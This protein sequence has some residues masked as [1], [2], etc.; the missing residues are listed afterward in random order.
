MAPFR[1]VV[2]YLLACACVAL[3]GAGCETEHTAVTADTP[4]EHPPADATK[5]NP[6]AGF[7]GVWEPMGS[8]RDV[9]SEADPAFTPATQKSI[10]RQQRMRDAGDI[11]YDYS[12]ICIPPSSPTMTTIGP[13]EILVDDKKITWLIEATSGIRWIWMDG[14]G[15]PPLE[16]LRLTANGHAIGR[17]EDDVLVVDSVGFLDKAMLYVNMPGNVSA[18]PSPQMRF[19]ERMRL[20]ED[21]QAII[22]ERTVYDPV[23]LSEPWKSTV[24]YERRDWELGETICMENNQVYF[25]FDPEHLPGS[26]DEAPE[27]TSGE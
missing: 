23:N 27:D 22:S 6:A 10:E 4:A 14:R 3:S 26:G 7:V 17:W 20:V 5:Q 16:E 8:P 11:S 13:Q 25:Y 15:H 1:R 21:G 24:R 2:R 12:A 19:V 18:Y 9:E